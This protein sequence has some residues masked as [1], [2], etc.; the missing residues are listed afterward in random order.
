M[1]AAD[2][3]PVRLAGKVALVTGAG[4]GIGRASAQRLAAEG[5]S[6]VVSDLDA[7]TAKATADAI[8][9]RGG[10]ATAIRADVRD[11]MDVD[12]LVAG[13]VN[14]YGAL[15]IAHNNA[16]ID[17]GHHPA[18]VETTEDEWDSIMAVNLKGVWLCMRAE[19]QV[20]AAAGSGSIINTASAA[21]FRAGPG[22]SAYGA[23]KAGVVILTK[24]AALEHAAS[25]I[26]VNAIAPGMVRTPMLEA[27]FSD[28]PHLEEML[29]QLTPLH[30]IS[31]PSEMAS[32]V[33]WLASDDASY[34]TGTA[35]LVDGGSLA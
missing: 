10:A 18:F 5:A 26:R 28:S 32:V 27:A 34:V 21:A 31:D 2:G 20:M 4:S 13:A 15:D 29:T 1:A 35:V 6:V 8:I 22:M 16:G 7:A 33:A 17:L 24:A 30:R 11:A 14:A 23:T 9:A 3:Y 12:A 25:G 19:L